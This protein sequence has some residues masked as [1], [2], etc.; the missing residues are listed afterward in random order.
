MTTTFV[1]ASGRFMRSPGFK[2][3]TLGLLCLLLLIPASLIWLLVSEREDR[4]R[5]VAREIA[6]TWGGSQRLIGPFITVP[7]EVDETRIVDDEETI[8]TVKREAV[9]LPDDLTITAEATTEVRS[10]GIFDVTV[11]GS[12]ITFEG[13]FAEPAG[14]AVAPADAR[15]RWAEARLS[16]GISSVRAIRNAVTLQ[17]DGETRAFE[18]SLGLS[19]TVRDETNFSPARDP[20][21]NLSG[22]HVPNLFLVNPRSFAFRIDLAL[23]GSDSLFIAPA[24]RDTTAS[25]VS[26]WPHPSFTGAALPE[27]ST[28]NPEVG[29]SAQWQV[30]HLARAVPLAFTLGSNNYLNQLNQDAFGVRFFQPVDY[31][32]LVDRALKYA[33]LFIG[34]VFLSVFVIEVRTAKRVHVVQY[35]FVGLALVLFYI[36]LLSLAEH[37]GFLIAYLLAGTATAALIGTYCA[38]SLDS[39]KYGGLVAAL[40]AGVFGVLYLFLRLE[41]YALLA[42]SIFAFGVLAVTM[43]TTQRIDWSGRSQQKNV[44]PTLPDG[45]A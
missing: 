5:D 20:G 41:D 17:M 15:F 24:A 7:Y 35:V 45:S 21:G 37:L 3:F 4:A 16:L 10:R 26:N 28:I 42:G 2:F 14:S 40:I 9:F 6:Q 27:A 44:P 33:I 34:V 1:D 12:D 38:R 25:I 30:P 43:F 31:Y 32:A 23:N 29:F 36:L 13:N 11:Y 18:P 19:G 8:T 22:I 39:A